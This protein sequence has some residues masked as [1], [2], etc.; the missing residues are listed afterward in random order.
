MNANA[1]CKLCKLWT[2]GVRDKGR[3]LS[4]LVL[5]LRIIYV[6]HMMKYF[7]EFKRPETKETKGP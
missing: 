1:P 7:L 6:E 2:K 4:F 3:R 5:P